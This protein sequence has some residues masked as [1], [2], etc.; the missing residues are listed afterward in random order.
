M[1][2]ILSEDKDLLPVNATMGHKRSGFAQSIVHVLH[3]LHDATIATFT[4][5]FIGKEYPHISWFFAIVFSLSTLF[6]TK[7]EEIILSD[8]WSLCQKPELQWGFSTF[9]DAN[10]ASEK[11][12]RLIDLS[13]QDAEWH[14]CHAVHCKIREVF[15]C[16]DGRWVCSYFTRMKDT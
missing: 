5:R 13:R 1:F 10:F 2:K 4:C 11:T 16:N 3:G 15:R 14:P 7:R 12:D 6:V 8:R 9:S